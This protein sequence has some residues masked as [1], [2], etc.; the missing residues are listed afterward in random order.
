LDYR[1]VLFQLEP[2]SP[3]LA[4]KFWGLRSLWDAPFALAL[5]LKVSLLSDLNVELEIPLTRLNRSE[6]GLMRP[7]VLVAAGEWA[8]R[9]LWRR[10]LVPQAGE[11]GESLILESMQCRFLKPVSAG[12][13]VRAQLEER[14]REPMLRKIRSGSEAEHELPVIFFD[15]NDQQ[16]ASFTGVWRIRPEGPK[17][18]HE[19]RNS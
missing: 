15:E 1:R 18:L 6:S 13:K 12:V 2:L 10:H 16:I 3:A 7:S 8:S 11:Q 14:E 9:L 19:G 5:G 17:V 4:R